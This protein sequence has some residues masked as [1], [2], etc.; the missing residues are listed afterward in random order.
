M[1]IAVIGGTGTLGRH[2]VAE[3]EARGHRVRTLSR[4]SAEHPVDLRTGAGLPEALAG[5][6]VVVDASNDQSRRAARTLVD[7][8]RRLLEAEESAGVGH[9]VCVSVLGCGRV[10]IG[11]FRTK[12]RQEGAVTEGPVPWTIVRAAQFH[13]L[14]AAALGSPVLPLPRVP[15]QPVAAADV[16]RA[17][18]EVAEEPARRGRVE[19][20]G[21]EVADVRALARTWRSVTGRRALTFPVPLPGRLGRELRSGALTSAHPDHRG[22]ATFTAWLER[23]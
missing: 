6:A 5:C 9:H 22:E 20:A 19:V 15:L 13:E 7:G 17:I 11:Y 18:A 8:T 2:V 4:S 10:P 21:P 12:A 16:A 1:R 23:R 3:L 14:V